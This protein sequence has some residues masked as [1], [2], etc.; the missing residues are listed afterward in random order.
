[1]REQILDA[2]S[3]ALSFGRIINLAATQALIHSSSFLILPV[4]LVMTIPFA[5][6]FAFYQ[7]VTA[8]A[9]IQEDDI[10]TVCKKSLSFANQWPKQNH[11]LILVFMAFAFILFLN[12]ATAIFILPY[13]LKKFFDFETIFTLSG[14]S[15]LNSTFLIATIG[16]TYL[17]VDPIVKTAY[18]LRCFYGG[19]MTTGEDIRIEL[20]KFMI[21]GKTLVAILA[22][23]LFAISFNASAAQK[24]QPPYLNNP[25]ASISIS[26][27][28]LNRSI[29]E[30]MNRTGFTPI[31][32][33]NVPETE[34]PTVEE[35]AFMRAMDPDGI[36]PKLAR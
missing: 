36:L 27:D 9:F 6:C 24:S 25:P 10:K 28:E 18:V 2:Q 4:A 35:V 5:W 26:P 8:Q 29:E 7:N 31:V 3:E 1:M 23:I 13:I 15:F 21:P 32:P 33:E 34:P 30:V 12:L 22:F 16:I 19:S 14:I 17:C 11:I 20:N